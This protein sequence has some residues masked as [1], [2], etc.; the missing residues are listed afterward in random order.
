MEQIIFLIHSRASTGRTLE[1][2]WPNAVL[3]KSRGSPAKRGTASAAERPWLATAAHSLPTCPRWHSGRGD[4]G[5]RRGHSPVRRRATPNVPFLAPP[6]PPARALLPLFHFLTLPGALCGGLG[7]DRGRFP[8]RD[9]RFSAASRPG[10]LGLKSGSSALRRNLTFPGRGRREGR[11]RGE[12][13]GQSRPRP[14]RPLSRGED[15]SAG[16]GRGRGGSKGRRVRGGGC[17]ARGDW[18]PLP[19]PRLLALQ[20]HPQ[21]PFRPLRGSRLPAQVLSFEA[22]N[23]AF[24]KFLK[25]PRPAGTHGGHSP[26][27]LH[28]RYSCQRSGCREE[29]EW[30]QAGRPVGRG[31]KRRP[32][33]PGSAPALGDRAAQPDLGGSAGQSAPGEGRAGGLE[34]LPGRGARPHHR[35]SCAEFKP[36]DNLNW[37]SGEAAGDPCPCP[38]S[39]PERSRAPPT[40]EL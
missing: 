9:S 21:P 6:P 24:Q 26:P 33:A 40:V 35:G 13:A 34:E 7:G 20:V 2:E 28:P 16:L 8:G 19:K 39:S 1:D 10:G 37:P 15:E 5:R 22:L 18:A 17:G 30:G 38:P 29:A 23:Q 11:P 36:G 27:S 12:R 31:P 4:S 25:L 32:G 3:M 14:A